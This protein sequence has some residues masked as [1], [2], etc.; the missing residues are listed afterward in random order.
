MKLFSIRILLLLLIITGINN[1]DRNAI[2]LCALADP[3]RFAYQ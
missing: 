2:L 1:L 3:A